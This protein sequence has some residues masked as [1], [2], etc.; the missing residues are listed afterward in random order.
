MG[1]LLMLTAI[2]GLFTS[3]V[4]AD[5]PDRLTGANVLVVYQAD[6]IDRDGDGQP[7]SAQLA[8]YYAARR[9]VP[10]ENLLG[11]KLTRDGKPIVTWG[12][13]TFFERILTP[14]AD[15]LA[16]KAADG[17]PLRD[18]VCL[19]ATVPPVPAMLEWGPVD[20][21]SKDRWRTTKR[22]SVDQFLIA[23]DE[24][25]KAGAAAP[26]GG[27]QAET[28][29]PIYAA[30]AGQDKSFAQLR[31]EQPG[32]VG[33]CLVSRLGADPAGGRDMIDG[34]LY[35]ERYLRLP[36]A[37]E[38]TNYRPTI[39]LDQKLDFQAADQIA[40]MHA[41]V[42]LTSG[43]GGATNPFAKG[44]GLLTP[45]PRV[46]D[47]QTEEVGLTLADAPVFVRKLAGVKSATQPAWNLPAALRPGQHVPMVT[48]KIRGVDSD[49]LVLEGAAVGPRDTPSVLYFPV[50]WTVQPVEIDAAGRKVTLGAGGVVRGYDPAGNRL[51]VEPMRGFAA[52]DTIVATWAGTFPSAD[53]FLY[54]GFYGLGR[55]E[56]VFQFLPGA[57]GV[58]VD[59]ACMNWANGAMRRGAAA[60]FGVTAEPLSAGIPHGH[61][62]IAALARGFTWA[63]ASAGATVLA[64]RWTG[65]TFGDPL[66]AP[67]RSLG[68]VDASPPVLGAI[69]AKLVGRDVVI[70]AELAGGNDDERAD[71]ARFAVDYGPTTTYGKRA[72][73]VDWP[74]PTNS[75]LLA[76]RRCGYSRVCSVKAPAPAKGQTMHFRVTARDPAGL[77]AVSK[78]QTFRP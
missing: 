51:R 16:S 63:E 50:G 3:T 25:V 58:H 45:W 37:D 8:N 62:M 15:K 42:G 77:E 56:D 23:I 71:V 38:K 67:F 28:R 9:A 66:Y 39:W 18:R 22:R 61:L 73:F 68:K 19:I 14:V 26:L 72:E 74:D 12:Y 43:Q 17:S 48:A 31:R 21:A 47:N 13:D 76:E 53:C 46:I 5:G 59:S 33:G 1:K 54:F 78:D 44:S 6:D 52:G 10:A 36:A 27:T 4:G 32:R 49:A 7:D 64:Q 11:L 34:A 57:I 40:S 55:Y 2:A 70:H 24:N 35:A 30:F 65:V 20:A 69:S 75:K 60:T 29:M 41:A